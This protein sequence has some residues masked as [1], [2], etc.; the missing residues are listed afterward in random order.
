MAATLRL[1]TLRN[2]RSRVALQATA[3]LRTHKGINAQGALLQSHDQCHKGGGR[4]ACV[5]EIKRSEASHSVHKYVGRRP[6][7]NDDEVAARGRSYGGFVAARGRSYV[8][9]PR[10][11]ELQEHGEV[12][13]DENGEAIRV[14]G[15]DT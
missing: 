2:F 14:L 13:E 7:T 4:D 11:R 8:S 9:P 5:Q 1:R 6:C 3:S 12:Q 15:G 10:T